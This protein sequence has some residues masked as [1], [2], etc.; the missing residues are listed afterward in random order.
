MV[1]NQLRSLEGSS[2][3]TPQCALDRD[4]YVDQTGGAIHQFLRGSSDPAPAATK[5]PWD[6]IGKSWNFYDEPID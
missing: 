1:T 5:V 3:P 2:S 6:P 4:L